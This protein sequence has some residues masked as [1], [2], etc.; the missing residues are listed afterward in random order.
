MTINLG[1]ELLMEV[2][3]KEG[4]LDMEHGLTTGVA[5]AGSPSP[6]VV[7]LPMVELADYDFGDPLHILVIPA[8]FHF[9]EAEALVQGII[10][11]L[12]L[13]IIYEILCFL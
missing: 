7:A 10:R 13:I 8:D 2:D 4:K 5:R 12:E 9:M 3:S 11:M 1:C 6:V